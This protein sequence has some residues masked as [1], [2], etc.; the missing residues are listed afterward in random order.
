MDP[1][2]YQNFPG[3]H[4]P[5]YDLKRFAGI[6]R[7][8]YG[9]AIQELKKGRKQS[10]WMWFIFPQLQGLGSSEKSIMYGISNLDEARCYLRHPMLC[11][12]LL[13]CCEILLR[14]QADDPT[15][16]GFSPLDSMKLKSS[17]TLFH[18]A[19]KA[20]PER[21]NRKV[22]DCLLDKFYLKSRKARLLLEKGI[23]GQQLKYD[24]ATLDILSRQRADGRMTSIPEPGKE[25][26][27]RTL[28]EIDE[29]LRSL[30]KGK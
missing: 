12:H 13:E 17:L 25:A 15:D 3:N 24:Q 16:L 7:I 20:E 4:E 29:I 26:P 18:E 23:S 27:A 5:S 19:A 30:P 2:E 10:D 8:R 9:T 28:E 11:R 14:S 1:E 21:E 22:F 6:H